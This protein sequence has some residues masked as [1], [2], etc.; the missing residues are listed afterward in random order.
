[1]GRIK[2]L[3]RAIYQQTPKHRLKTQINA[4]LRGLYENI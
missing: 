2:G 3:R 1:M 4:K